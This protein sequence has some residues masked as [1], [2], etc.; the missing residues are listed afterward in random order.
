MVGFSYSIRNIFW[1]A[2]GIIVGGDFDLGLG[3]AA[4]HVVGGR[5]RAR[6]VPLHIRIFKRKFLYAFNYFLHLYTILWLKAG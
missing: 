2:G 6:S 1:R 4:C 3:G 5:V